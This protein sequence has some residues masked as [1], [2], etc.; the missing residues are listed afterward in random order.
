MGRNEIKKMGIDEKKIEITRLWILR[1][2][3]M[4]KIENMDIKDH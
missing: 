1:I 4:R 3:E 2:N